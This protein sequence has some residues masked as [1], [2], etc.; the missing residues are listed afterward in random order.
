MPS[1]YK[2]VVVDDKQNIVKPCIYRGE[3]CMYKFVLQLAE[4]Q[5]ELLNILKTNKA[6]EMTDQ[7]KIDF[8]N[9][10]ECYICDNS[11]GAFVKHSK[12]QCKVRDH[13]HLTGEYRG[14]AHSVCNLG[15]NT[16]N[17]KI[18]VFFQPKEL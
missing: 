15:Y 17:I 5:R 9:A 16:N 18:P 8:E 3:D 13:N 4:I 12:N 7:N 2:L 14:A 10:T 6:I 11:K 1:G